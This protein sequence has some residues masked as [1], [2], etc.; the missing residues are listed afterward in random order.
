M[1]TK[2][3][4]SFRLN[5]C[6]FETFMI[7]LK[8]KYPFISRTEAIECMFYHVHVMLLSN[9]AYGYYEKE[10]NRMFVNHD[11]SGEAEK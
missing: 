5:E 8:K 9:Q 1:A 3:Q 7:E 4:Y 2:K 6:D 11:Y 10:L